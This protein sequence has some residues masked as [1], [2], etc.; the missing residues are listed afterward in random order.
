MSE[1]DRHRRCDRVPRLL[2]V[3]NHK[4]LMDVEVPILNQAGFS[5]FIPKRVPDD[6]GYRSAKID[7]QYDA[8]LQLPAEVRSI[9]NSHAFYTAPWSATLTQILNRY[10]DGLITSVSAYTTPLFEAIS[11][12]DGLVVAR[13]FG[14]ED[15]ARYT[16][17]FGE[18][19]LEAV[20]GLGGRF[21]FGQGFSNLA[22]IEDGR[23][24]SRA[25]T[26]PLGVPPL[27]WSRQGS[28]KGK[29]PTLLA[30]CPNILD[31]PYYGKIYKDLKAAF[32]DLPHLIMG[33]QNERP[34]DEAVLPYMTDGELLD[35]Y[36]RVA[37]FAYPSQ[38][39]RHVHYSPIE[40]MI[41]GCPVLYRSGGL[42]DTLA[43]RPLPGACR[44]VDEM[45]AK[46][47]ALIA[48]APD[49]R[50]QILATQ[51][52]IVETFSTA[53][54]SKAWEGLLGPLRAAVL[55]SGQARGGRS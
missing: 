12:F 3:V 31:S 49:L 23:L 32:R 4:T 51:H 13:V 43:G 25:V 36:A 46:A 7:Y 40:A 55:G 44:D 54:S 17:F 29:Q 47:A 33:R 6:P 18:T 8:A 2:W 50:D 41:I 27:V 35:L 21:V 30:L 28:W 38:E 5:V 10:F 52:L 45:K 20:K 11:K 9:L 24:A 14:R 16:T 39:P 26:L 48:G 19:W 1:I 37:V 15:P 53:T 22:Q 34:R 42:L